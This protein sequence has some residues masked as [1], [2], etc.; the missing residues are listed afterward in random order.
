MRSKVTLEERKDRPLP[1]PH[2]AVE[3]FA[4][5]I[6]AQSACGI[7]LVPQLQSLFPSAPPLIISIAGSSAV[8]PLVAL[9]YMM[10]R[11]RCAPPFHAPSRTFRDVA[12]CMLAALAAAHLSVLLIP[13]DPY[14]HAILS[15]PSPYRFAAAPLIALWIPFLEEALYR[16]FCL[17]LL[18][19]R[20]GTIAAV[21]ASSLL[22]VIPHGIWGGMGIN[23]ALI[24]LFSLVFSCAYLRG[25][26]SLAV[27]THV[28]AVSYQMLSAN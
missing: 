4:V 24:F 17:S 16:G 10:A 9:V 19:P 26:M 22:F 12:I 15:L 18:L 27:L 5:H 2:I 11:T 20:L 8:A 25:G 7:F 28:L 21:L 14:V 3:G 1:G 23:L 13:H 6:A